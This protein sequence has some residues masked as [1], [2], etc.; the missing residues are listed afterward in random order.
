MR[1]EFSVQERRMGELLMCGRD[2]T[3]AEAV[4]KESNLPVARERVTILMFLE[5]FSG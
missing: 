5:D 1:R 2:S 3:E 4:V